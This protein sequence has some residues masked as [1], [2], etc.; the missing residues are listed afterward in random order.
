MT[1]PDNA[2]VIDAHI[3]ICDPHHHLWE[4]EHDDYLVD[5]FRRDTQSGHNVVSTV[6]IEVK[7]HYRPEGPEELRPVGETEW[8]VA[9]ATDVLMRGIVGFVDLTRGAAADDVIAAHLTAADGRLRG[10]RQPVVWDAE[11][12]VGRGRVPGP[13][14]LMSPAFRAGAAR[15]V[16]HHLVFDA[17]I[18]ASQLDELR[19]FAA[20]LPDLKIVLNHL[21]FPLGV[22]VH[23]ERR[24]EVEKS[25]RTHLAAIA[26]CE[27]VMLKLGGLGLPAM[28]TPGG[29]FPGLASAEEV[30]GIWGPTIRWCIELFGIDR[31]MFESNFPVDRRL[32]T[33]RDLWSAYKLMTREFSDSERDALL[34]GTAERVYRLT[35]DS[36]VSSA[37][38]VSC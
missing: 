28:A 34:R 7:S 38:Q 14:L 24:A 6:Y 3:A 25:W 29:K 12:V 19:L 35:A 1:D 2:E 5:D 33:Y 30:A 32:C 23:A 16:R 13:Q 4:R 36:S 26:R 9:Q 37:A 27:N 31:C 11:G 22:G 21:G 17:A 15:L 18:Y 20:A 8:V 10:V